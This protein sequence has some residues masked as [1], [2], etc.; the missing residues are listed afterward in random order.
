M[1]VTPNNLLSIFKAAYRLGEATK[2]YKANPLVVASE[3]EIE[4]DA[5]PIILNILDTHFMGHRHGV[6]PERLRTIWKNIPPKRERDNLHSIII[7]EFHSNS[8]LYKG[9]L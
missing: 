7:D 6:M 4:T 2:T 1:E 3:E 8:D 9:V 5:F